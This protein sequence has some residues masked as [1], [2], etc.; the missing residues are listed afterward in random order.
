MEKRRVRFFVTTSCLNTTFLSL[1]VREQS[2]PN[3]LDILLIDRIP[4]RPS[5]RESIIQA[6][7]LHSFDHFYDLSVLK[8]EES[9]FRP[10][11]RKKWTRKLKSKPG[12]KQVYDGLYKRKLKALHQ[13]W[14]ELLDEKLAGIDF[15]NAEVEICSQAVMQLTPVLRKR[16]PNA[17]IHFFEHGLGDYL[18]IQNQ[19]GTADTY[20]CVFGETYS[21]YLS[22]RGVENQFVKTFCPDFHASSSEFHRNFPQVTDA[23]SQLPKTKKWILLCTQPLEEFHIPNKYWDDFFA[24]M[25]KQLPK[26]ESYLILIK[27]HPRQAMD[28]CQYLLDMLNASRHE[29]RIWDHPESRMLSLEILFAWMEEQ[30]DYV[31]SPFSSS[32][33][34]LSMLYPGTGTKFYYSVESLE[35]YLSVVPELIR[36]RWAELRIGIENIFSSEARDMGK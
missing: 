5:S 21:S 18:D 23:F 31:F 7:N 6:S 34:Y 20:N 3:D 30:V 11:T 19:V 12:F 22:T 15:S 9:S 8:E 33:F 35:P 10:S 32:I 26:D 27:P 13:S 28:V 17:T 36:K 24:L 4:V 16:F 1:Y 2:A 29:A 14:N 25:E